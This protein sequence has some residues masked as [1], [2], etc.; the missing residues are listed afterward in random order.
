MSQPPAKATRV[1][2]TTPPPHPKAPWSGNSMIP[3]LLALAV[4]GWF[5][6]FRFRRATLEERKGE[7]ERLNQLQRLAANPLEGC[8]ICTACGWF[9]RPPGVDPARL[10]EKRPGV[11]SGIG[12]AFGIG[13]IIFGLLTIE[14]FC[15]GLLPLGIGIFLCMRHV[16]AANAASHRTVVGAI[17]AV[18]PNAC[19][20]CSNHSVIPASSPNGAYLIA[21][22]PIINSA[23]SAEIHN[24]QQL[25]SNF[26]EGPKA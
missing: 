12:M 24:V 7:Q 13:L 17:H 2:G 11:V 23:A 1:A 22:N 8:W 9:G 21:S 3:V 14:L 26:I 25:C 18:A 4:A 10:P 15:I 6:W 16:K 20:A 5:I 19:P